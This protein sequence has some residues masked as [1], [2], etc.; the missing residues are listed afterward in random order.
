MDQFWSMVD[1]FWSHQGFLDMIE[2]ALTFINTYKYDQNEVDLIN[3]QSL[4]ASQFS[5]LY[6]FFKRNNIVP[7]YKDPFWFRLFGPET[8][9]YDAQEQL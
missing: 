5:L 3:K 9:M 7:T 2:E 8:S 6:E 1:Q 4:W